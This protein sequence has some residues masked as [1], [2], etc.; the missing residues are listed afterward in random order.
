[1]IFTRMG[2]EVMKGVSTNRSQ[3]PKPLGILCLEVREMRQ[4]LERRLMKDGRPRR[5]KIKCCGCQ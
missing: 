3:R 4:N 2:L 1:M 5:R